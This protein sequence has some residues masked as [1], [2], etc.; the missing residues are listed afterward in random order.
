MPNVMISHDGFKEK[1]IVQKMEMQNLSFKL[2]VYKT[3]L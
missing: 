1:L 3:S 2:I